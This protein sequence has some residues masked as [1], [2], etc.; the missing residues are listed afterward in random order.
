VAMPRIARYDLNSIA[1]SFPS[2]LNS[3]AAYAMKHI[4]YAGLFAF[5]IPLFL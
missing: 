4:K 1:Y 5:Q 2:A 3:W